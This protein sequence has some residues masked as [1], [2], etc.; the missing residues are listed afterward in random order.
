MPLLVGPA[1]PDGRLRALDQPV[2][3]AGGLV[4]RPWQDDDAPSLV[5][6]HADP[7]ILRWHVRTFTGDDHARAWLRRWPDQWAEETGASWAVV[8]QE[9]GVVGQVG[10]RTISLFNGAA[11]LSYWTAPWARRRGVAI[12]AVRAMTAWTFDAVGLHRLWLKHA[13]TNNVSCRVALASG[14][15]AEGTQRESG[16]HADGWHDMHVHARLSTDRP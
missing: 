6:A 4:L 13:A 11:Q 5:R 3:D 9:V 10:L 1:V 16:L 15:V 8:D 2:L 7:G 12:A 14:Y